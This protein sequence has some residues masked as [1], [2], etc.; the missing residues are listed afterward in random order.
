MEQ[1]KNTIEDIKE[2]ENNKETYKKVSKL[3][4]LTIIELEKLLNIKLKKNNY[5][6][7]KFGEPQ[8]DKYVVINFTIQD[9]KSDRQEYDSRN[10]LKKLIETIL[11]STNWRLM[12]DGV[13][14]RLGVLS[15]RLKGYEAEDDLM[16]LVKK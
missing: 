14:Y 12:S 3:K 8:I 15:G 10:N 9:E 11:F 6:K 16:K 5:I 1:F 4:K 13:S 7:L 2:R